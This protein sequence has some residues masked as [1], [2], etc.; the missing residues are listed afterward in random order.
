[1][2]GWDDQEQ[3]HQ[4]GQ[5][6]GGRVPAPLSRCVSSPCAWLAQAHRACG[7]VMRIKV[8]FSSWCA[9][10]SNRSKPSQN[11][12]LLQK[13]AIF[14]YIHETQSWLSLWKK[15]KAKCKRTQSPSHLL[16]TV[17]A[18]QHSLKSPGQMPGGELGPPPGATCVQRTLKSP[19]E[20]PDCCLPG[21]LAPPGCHD[22]LSSNPSR[23]LCHTALRGQ[24]SLWCR[25]GAAQRR[26]LLSPHLS[27]VPQPAWCPGSPHTAKNHPPCFFS[28][29]L[30]PSVPLLLP[31]VN[32][33][34]QSGSRLNFAAISSD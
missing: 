17:P 32:L 34:Y 4:H 19:L 21:C 27:P 2:R 10:Q 12:C 8:I 24:R 25:T 7:Q 6:D 3:P 23:D 14:L 16:L 9:I 18:A 29:F 5:Q 20:P 22:H 1:M 31:P 11:I 13:L 28:L 26:H 33:D 30:C 15:L